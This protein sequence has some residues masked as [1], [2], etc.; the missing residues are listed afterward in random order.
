MKKQIDLLA[1]LKVNMMHFHLDV[2]KRQDLGGT[3]SVFGSVDGDG[4]IVATTSIKTQ[5]FQCVDQYVEESVK[6]VM[7]I[8]V[9]YI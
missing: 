3:N 6:A 9:N 8:V 5:A 7:Q 1:S 2:Y 4:E